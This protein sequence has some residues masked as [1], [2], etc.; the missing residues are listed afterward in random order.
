[1]LTCHHLGGMKVL[2][3]EPE[4]LLQSHYIAVLVIALWR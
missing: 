3:C 4:L 2:G 1:M